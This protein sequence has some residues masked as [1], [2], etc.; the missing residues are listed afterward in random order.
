MVLFGFGIMHHRHRRRHGRCRLR[1][2][3]QRHCG[4]KTNECHV[5]RFVSPQMSPTLPAT[6]PQHKKKRQLRA[7]TGSIQLQPWPPAIRRQSLIL[8]PSHAIIT[9]TILHSYVAHRLQFT[10]KPLDMLFRGWF[11]VGGPPMPHLVLTF[12]MHRQCH[13]FQV[14][15]EWSSDER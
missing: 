12:D 14:G 6:R 10:C 3:S 13:Q 7:P 5:A 1:F 9:A 15:V 4:R 2:S 11:S 8:L